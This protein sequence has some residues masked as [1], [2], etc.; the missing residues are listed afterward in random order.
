MLLEFRAK[1]Y[2]SFRDEMVFSMTPAPKISDLKHSEIVQKGHK[3]NAKTARLVPITYRALCSSVVYGPNAS[4]KSNIFGAMGAFQAI[5]RR[6]HIRDD[7]EY[8]SYD[9]AKDRLALIPNIGSGPDD[10]V[11]FGI[12]FNDGNFVIEYAISMKL[13]PFLRGFRHRAVMSEVLHV[14]GHA[15]FKRL[16]GRISVDCPVF[17]SNEFAPDFDISDALMERLAGQNMEPSDLFLANGFRVIFSP[18]LADRVRNW[19]E[20]KMVVIYHADKLSI[21][22]DPELLADENAF[23]SPDIDGAAR[24][25]GAVNSIGYKRMDNEP[26]LM[27]MVEGVALPAECFESYGTIRMAS[28]FPLIVCALKQGQVLAIDEFD[29]SIHPMAL[30]S[31]IKV[32]H[33]NDI[34]KYG[35]QLI[36]NTHNPIFLNSD[37]FRRDEIKFVE[38]GEDTQ[39]SELYMLSD[40]GTSGQDGVRKGEN[41]LKNYFINQY[42]AIRDVDFAPLLE[43]IMGNQ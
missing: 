1:N 14:N 16:D 26:M 19:I 3:I 35:A 25:M 18:K 6:G 43:Q 33:N 24:I 13:G 5:I 37:L 11:D 32:F 28:L 30:M 40:F 36:F 29:A 10:T 22:C 17:L 20:E 15:V 8:T 38:R 9:L 2:K 4:G 27:S 34:N 23:I 39:T 12:K 42:G 7:K 31:L 41:Y 21:G